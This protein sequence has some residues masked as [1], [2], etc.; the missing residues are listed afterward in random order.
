MNKKPT[1]IKRLDG[2]RELENTPLKNGIIIAISRSINKKRMAKLK[3]RM[4]KP[5]LRPNA[6]SNPHSNPRRDSPSL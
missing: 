4:Q 6:P 5:A 1:P 3:K 2:L